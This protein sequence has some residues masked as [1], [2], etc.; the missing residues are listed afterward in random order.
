[1][2]FASWYS[3]LNHNFLIFQTVNCISSHFFHF[4]QKLSILERVRLPN[5]RPSVGTGK[6]LTGNVESIEE[7]PSKD[8][9][10]AGFSN[11]ERFRTAFRMKAYTLRQSSEGIK[12]DAPA[13]RIKGWVWSVSFRTRTI[14]LSSY[15]LSAVYICLIFSVMF[16]YFCLCQMPEPYQNQP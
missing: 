9:K 8:P 11:R 3:I 4:S 1:M 13:I 14:W 10:P 7:S 15:Q 5:A 6:K 12:R 16:S 2:L